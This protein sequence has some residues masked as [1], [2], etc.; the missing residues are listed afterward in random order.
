MR[1]RMLVAGIIHPPH[2][3]VIVHDHRISAAEN[4][5]Q[6]IDIPKALLAIAGSQEPAVLDIV[7]DPD[8]APIPELDDDRVDEVEANARFHGFL[9]KLFL[10]IDGSFCVF[11]AGKQDDSKK[12]EEKGKFFH[13][14]VAIEIP[15]NKLCQIYKIFKTPY[16]PI[17]QSL[18]LLVLVSE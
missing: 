5:R 10:R 4:N 13:N 3:L 9:F 12:N 6:G 18:N 11:L 14:I 17:A 16:R 2:L 8:R 7:L 1:K 15:D